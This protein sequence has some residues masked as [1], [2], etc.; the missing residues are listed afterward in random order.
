MRGFSQ[1]EMVIATAVVLVVTTL[2]ALFL[3]VTTRAT[4]RGTLRVEMQQQAVVATQQILTAM[5]KSTSGGISV[6]SGTAPRAIA[7]C[8]LS[9]DSAP[10]QGD[11]TLRWAKF[12]YIYYLDDSSHQLRLRQWPPGSVAATAD[13]QIISAPRRLL[14]DRLATVL[15]GSSPRE[16]VLASG[17]KEFNLTYPPG[18]SDDTYVQPLTIQL[19]LQ[20][21]GLTGHPEPETFTYTRTIFL[22]E[23]R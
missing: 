15:A 17:V 9:Q 20:R 8:P 21:K 14:P 16:N 18:G 19:I 22:P 4:M 10:V 7:V 23:Q 2:I 1:I 13:E 12:F 3:S 11:G 5:R 6:R